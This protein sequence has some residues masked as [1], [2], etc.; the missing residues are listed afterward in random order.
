[1]SAARLLAAAAFAADKHRRQRRK[2]GDATPYINHPLAVAHLLAAVGGVTDPDVLAAAL[3]HDTLEDTAT[4]PAELDAAFGEPVRRLVE[5]LTDDKGL[6]KAE[7]KRL[8][9]ERAP[10]KSP[11]AALVKLADKA[12]NVADLAA[13]PPAG[14]PAERVR[15]YLNWAERVVGRLPRVNP[16]LEAHFAAVLGAARAKQG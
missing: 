13:C 1:M 12:C 10:H 6:P 11:G 2:D 7:R 15:E 4:T 14:W 5:E 16:P 8:Q 9:E 3:L